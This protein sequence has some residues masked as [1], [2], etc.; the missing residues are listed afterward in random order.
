AMFARHRAAENPNM[1]RRDKPA[2]SRDCTLQYFWLPNIAPVGQ[3]RRGRRQQ[4]ATGEHTCPPPAGSP[5]RSEVWKP[6]RC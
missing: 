5:R 1:A 2:G 6:E 3:A 4:P